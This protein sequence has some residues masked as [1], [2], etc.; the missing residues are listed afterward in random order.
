M[1]KMR[2]DD[3]SLQYYAGHWSHEFELQLLW[4]AGSSTVGTRY[5]TY[6]AP[7]W[8]WASYDGHVII[9]NWGSRTL[10]STLVHIDVR[11]VS[12]L[13]GAV[14]SGFIRMRGPLCRAI[15]THATSYSDEELDDDDSDEESRQT[16]TLLGSG[17]DV[18]FSDLAWDEKANEMAS[19]CDDQN[20][21]VLLGVAQA[22]TV[23]NRPLQGLLLRL[24]R[25]EN[26]Q[27]MRVG[28]FVIEDEIPNSLEDR[29]NKER[30]W[31]AFGRVYEEPEKDN[32]GAL[33]NAFDAMDMPASF[34]ERMVD[35]RYEVTIV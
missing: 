14:S 6:I 2:Q 15:H 13:F 16:L 12:D 30:E 21:I 35:N 24:T 11:P 5:Q 10:W 17:I 27:Y 22:E 20:P 31:A 18:R 32:F 4:F 34:Y 9:S 19:I 25:Q 23:H 29:Q 7:S 8:S 26:G 28:Y 3:S 33:L 1:Y